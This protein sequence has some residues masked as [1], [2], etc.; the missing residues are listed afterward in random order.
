[1]AQ[2]RIEL[3]AE[4]VA[5]LGEGREIVVP[6]FDEDQDFDEGSQRVIITD[7]TVVLRDI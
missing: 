6:A 4:D 3:G 2:W 5:A 7:V 1:M